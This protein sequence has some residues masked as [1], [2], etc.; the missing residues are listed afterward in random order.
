M[1]DQV[2]P[3]TRD[4]GPANELLQRFEELKQ[5]RRGF[6]RIWQEIRELI[7]PSS[8]DFNSLIVSPGSPL[9]QR[10]WD[11][12]A[13]QSLTQFAGGLHGNLTNPA[14]RWFEL[15][16]GDA[17]F[18]RR[19]EIAAW[20]ESAS[21]TIYDAMSDGSAQYHQ[22][23][24]EGYIDI[25]SFGTTVTFTSRDSRG[26]IFFRPLPLAN[27]WLA[28]NA[29]G[30]VDT[31]FREIEFTTRQAFQEFGETNLPRGIKTESNWAKKWRF[32]HAIYPRE[33]RHLWSP[34][35][36]ENM[37]WASVYVSIDE[38]Q[39]VQTDGFLS[40][41][42]QCPR[43]QKLPGETYGR[44][45]AMDCLA[46]VRVLNAAQKI[47][48]KSAALSSA[49][50]IVVDDDGVVM[51]IKLEPYGIIRRREGSTVEPLALN[52]NIAVN[53]E[54]I[55][56][57][58]TDIQAAFF[59]DM[60]SMPDFGSRDRVTA[61]EVFEKRDDRLRQI[62][63]M[64]G[65]LESELHNPQIARI[66][67][68]LVESRRIA[69]PPFKMKER[70]LRVSNISPAALAQRSIRGQ[71]FMRFISTVMP[72]TQFDPGLMDGIDLRL[73]VQEMASALNVT[74]RV[75]RTKE[76]AD[77]IAQA[78]NEQAQANQA[79]SMAP[80]AAVALKDVATAAEKSPEMLSL[81]TQG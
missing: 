31:L 52:G 10:I 13:G 38:P 60:F 40:F 18:D 68:L 50:P 80:Q 24:H 4:S 58:K 27:C 49:P 71:S 37:A 56:Q 29:A 2:Q 15:T 36:K 65:R 76:D 11:N 42:C 61:Q 20:L 21:D 9:R 79:M 19:P 43:W 62:A 22:S 81:L 46:N 67:Q 47:L 54:F 14:A 78:R 34:Q 63:P 5:D 12:T 75:L 25:G 66:Y 73:G 55:R 39:I 16:T 57:L 53:I 44:S 17:E 30:E 69:S 59:A 51:P 32:L 23:L 72:L 1:D 35:T 3:G 6:E 70:V 26:R 41:P 74:R 8:A 33:E 45:P 28:E 64:L 48:M 77:Q 7:R